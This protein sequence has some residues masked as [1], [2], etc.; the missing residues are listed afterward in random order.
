[1]KKKTIA[2]L[3]RILLNDNAYGPATGRE[4]IIMKCFYIFLL[5]IV[6]GWSAL[7]N[8]AYPQIPPNPIPPTAKKPKKLA[9]EAEPSEAAKASAFLEEI[10][11]LYYIPMKNG[12]DSFKAS[13]LI[14]QAKNP[15]L[16]RA[17][18]EVKIDYSW[19]KETNEQI[20]FKGARSGILQKGLKAPITGI[21]KD[22]VGAGFFP[23][24]EDHDLGLI[25]N[26]NK[27]SILITEEGKALG[28]VDF[29]RDTKIA[30]QMDAKSISGRGAVGLSYQVVDSKL[31]FEGKQLITGGGQ[32]RAKSNYQYSGYRK[33]NGFSL[34]SRMTVELNK[35]LLEFKIAYAS[36]NGKK[37]AIE[38]MKKDDV[39]E[40]VKKFY[41]KYGKWT[42]PEKLKAIAQ[43][44]ESRHELASE[45]I[46]KKGMKDR[47]LDIRTRSAEALGA[48]KCRNIVSSLAK[49]MSANEKNENVYLAIIAALGAIGDKKAVSYLAKDNWDPKDGDETGRNKAQAK[50]IAL[51]KIRSRASVD[52]LIS[53]MYKAKKGKIRSISRDLTAAL[54]SLTGQNFGQ[55]RD[56]WKSWW[57][58]NKSNIKLEEDR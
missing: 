11:K 27:V 3:M 15:G 29:D 31:R 52:A 54:K 21:W 13:I 12:L 19:D 53:R 57:T 30:L 37:A 56:K 1:M 39:R 34:P 10:L 9:E 55:D 58:K 38:S 47:D 44:E 5:V 35:D 24:F 36:I 4:L 26:E 20:E 33:V 18:K 49:A 6:I 51:G 16:R 8:G 22:I 17:T 41:S 40:L 46:L 7:S 50:V 28:S 14:R 32:G 43:L 25:E 48:M 23:L 45:A 42:A 2:L